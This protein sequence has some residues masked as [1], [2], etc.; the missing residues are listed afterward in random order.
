MRVSYPVGQ[1]AI[2][3]SWR[4]LSLFWADGLSRV[5]SGAAESLFTEELWAMMPCGTTTRRQ[6]TSF[7]RFQERKAARYHWKAKTVLEPKT[8]MSSPKTAMASRCQSL[9]FGVIEMKQNRFFSITLLNVQ[10]VAWTQM[11]TFIASTAHQ[12]GF[13]LYAKGSKKHDLHNVYKWEI[14]SIKVCG[15]TIGHA[16]TRRPTR[17]LI[18]EWARGM[19]GRWGR[20]R[21]TWGKPG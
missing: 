1:G 2:T 17:D 18:R 14:M 13:V 5:A 21:S 16:A 9:C 20:R 4:Q 8:V 19:P 10:M 6:G 3:Q 15:G 11:C 12:T 7:R